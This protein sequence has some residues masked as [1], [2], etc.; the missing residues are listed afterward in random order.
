LSE[1]HSWSLSYSKDSSLS[2]NSNENVDQLQST[3]IYSNNSTSIS[4]IS[5]LSYIPHNNIQQ[6]SIFQ[7]CRCQCLHLVNNNQL[8]GVANQ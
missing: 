3:K 1:C 5:N 6:K 8:L 7:C 4:T 2:V